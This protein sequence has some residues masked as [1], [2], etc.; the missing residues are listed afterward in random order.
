MA[1][2]NQYIVGFELFQRP[3]DT[4]CFQSFMEKLLA[5]GL[6]VPE[7]VVTDAGYVSEQNYFI[8]IRSRKSETS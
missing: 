5:R 8:C 4:C 6:R 1:T 2:Q 7:V 3:G